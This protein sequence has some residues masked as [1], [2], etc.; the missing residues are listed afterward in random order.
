MD[1]SQQM[2]ANRQAWDH[3]ARSA[4]GQYRTKKLVA[5]PNALSLMVKTDEPF[6]LDHLPDHS[7]AGLDLLHLQCSIGTDTLSWARL[8][9]RATGLDFSGEAI[10]TAQR[11]AAEAG[12]PV[13]FVESN[14]YDAV[15]TL[16]AQRFD[17]VYSSEGVL[18]WLPDL[19]G[20]ARQIYGLLR[21]GGLFYIRDE[22]PILRTF[23]F[24]QTDDVLTVIH[25]YFNS[26]QPHQYLEQPDGDVDSLVFEWPHSLSEIVTAVLGAG[27]RV[28]ALLEHKFL[29]WLGLP[30][31]VEGESGTWHLPRPD[32]A[33]LSFTLVARRPA[34]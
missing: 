4:V 14:V 3:A 2:D 13:E 33:P 15:A 34:D 10:T 1:T 9:A 7:V 27:L 16:G 26:G 6:L 32:V 29:T 18:C 5:D 19:A 24:E 25:P 23:D 22:H 11:L 28:E 30:F 31:M 17:I 20:W 12:L 8:G 21:P